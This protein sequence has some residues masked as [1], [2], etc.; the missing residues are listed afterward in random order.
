MWGVAIYAPTTAIV[1]QKCLRNINQIPM[2]QF[3]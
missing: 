3:V 2:Q 1:F